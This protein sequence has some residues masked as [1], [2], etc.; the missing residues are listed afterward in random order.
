[1]TRGL[2]GAAGRYLNLPPNRWIARLIHWCAHS[3]IGSVVTILAWA[4]AMAA[5][6]WVAR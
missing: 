2:R 5:I 3:T 4:A 1:M 6:V